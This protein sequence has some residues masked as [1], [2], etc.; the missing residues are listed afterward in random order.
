MAKVAKEK[1]E[2]D[3]QEVDAA[4]VKGNKPYDEYLAARKAASL[5]RELFEKAFIEAA[6]KA[7]KV[8]D[9]QTLRFSYKFGK[10]SVALDDEDKPKKAD[11]G[12]FKL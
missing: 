4:S 7:K 2:L 1:K 9:G 8:P 12:T 10:L 3:W 6:R 11:A 5:K